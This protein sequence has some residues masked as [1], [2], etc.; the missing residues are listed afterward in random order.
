MDPN[1]TLAHIV[2]NTSSI[3]LH[4]RIAYPSDELKHLRLPSTC[5]ADTCYNA[6]TET[7]NITVKY[8][9]QGIVTQTIAPLF[10]LCIFASAK[11]LLS[12]FS[13]TKQPHLFGG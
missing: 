6:A 7:A 2:H 8:L 1:M 10:S 3:F 12:K 5:S 13:C 11:A 4:Q 9:G